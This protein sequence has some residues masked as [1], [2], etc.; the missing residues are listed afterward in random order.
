M[1]TSL[2]A[3]LCARCKNE[4]P[5]HGLDY[6]RGCMDAALVAL[7]DA[8][9]PQITCDLRCKTVGLEVLRGPYFTCCRGES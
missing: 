5:E 7:L 2:T 6:C 8:D 1:K 4:L 3:H 9:R